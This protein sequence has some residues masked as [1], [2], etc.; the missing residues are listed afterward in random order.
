MLKPAKLEDSSSRAGVVEPARA[1]AGIM[2]VQ[3]DGT[4]VS[5]A[6]PAIAAEL[7]AGPQAIQWVTTGNLL[8][9]AGLLIPARAVADK[10]GRKRTFLMGV[11][12]PC[13]QRLSAPYRLSTKVAAERINPPPYGLLLV[14][15]KG[16]HADLPADAGP[17]RHHRYGVVCPHAGRQFRNCMVTHWLSVAAH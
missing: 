10:I 1:G 12:P 14:A 17:T 3:L 11:G 2:V 9:F 7:G 16:S 4:V 5:V 6:N 8:V 13:S 15:R